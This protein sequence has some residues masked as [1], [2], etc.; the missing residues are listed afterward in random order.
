MKL[1]VRVRPGS[2][3]TSVE[4]LDDGSYRVHVVAPP[5]KGKANIALIAALADH[6]GV[7]Q[8]SVQILAGHAAHT[9]IIE[10]VE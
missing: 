2:R 3:Q 6:F 1:T 5:E 9:K 4:K 7:P 8:R 10:V